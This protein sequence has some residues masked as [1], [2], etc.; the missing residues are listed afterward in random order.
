MLT[1]DTLSRLAQVRGRCA[2]SDA[3][4]IELWGLSIPFGPVTA[5]FVV[6]A[7]LFGPPALAGWLA[8]RRRSRA[9]QHILAE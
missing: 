6:T 8:R 4:R 9:M 7:L 5:V 3:T 2:C 1:P